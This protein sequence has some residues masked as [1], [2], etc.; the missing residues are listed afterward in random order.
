MGKMINIGY[1]EPLTFHSSIEANQFVDDWASK[2][3]KFLDNHNKMPT[4]CTHLIHP[5]QFIPFV[6]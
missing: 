5:N 1:S 4:P 6:S 3:T 2:K